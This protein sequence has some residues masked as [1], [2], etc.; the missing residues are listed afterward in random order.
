MIKSII[1]RRR[2]LQMLPALPLICQAQTEG[3]AIRIGLTP[4][5]LDDQLGFLHDWRIWLELHL[6]LPVKF[7]QR[8][9]YRDI[10]DALKSGDIKAAWVCGYPFIR[11]RGVMKLLAVPRYKNKLTYTSNFIVNRKLDSIKKVGDLK[12]TVFV[13]S[14]P[15]SNSGYLYPQYRFKQLGINPLTFFKRTFFTWSHRNTIDAVASGLADAGAVDSYIWE[16][17]KKH[18]PGIVADT[19]I[20]EIS[21]AFGFPPL[22]ISHA[23]SV[24][25]AEKL[26]GVICKMDHDPQGKALLKRLGLDGFSRGTP[27]LFNG[28]QQMY[29][30]LDADR[31]SEPGNHAS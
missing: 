5:I 13:F 12:N 24:D 10:T 28:I 11:N 2:F 23:L 9:K 17:Y 15:D 21:P 30:K 1:N 26:I 8:R 27:D 29:L 7:V 3:E 16:Q 19:R 22:V 25:V 4:V 14:D 31:I 6:G 20:I 18:H